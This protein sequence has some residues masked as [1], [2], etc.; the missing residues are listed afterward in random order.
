[1]WIGGD[2]NGHVGGTRTGFEREHVG[3]SWGDR[4]VEG[5]EILQFAQAYDLGIVNTFFQTK[6]EHTITYKSGWRMSVIDYILIRRNNTSQVKDCKVIPGE[7][8]ATQPRILT[9][10]ICIKT[11]RIVKL[12]MRKQHIKWWRLKDRDEIRKLASRLEVKINDV[13]EWNQ[14]EALLLDTAKSVL[15]Q[16]TG[17]GAYNE[18][19]AWWW[20]EEVQKAVK[21][22]RLKFKQYQQSRCDKDKEEF[23][24]ANKRAK[25]EVAK[26]KER[27]YKD[28]YDKLDSIEGQK[29]IYKLYKTRERRTRDITDIAY[30]KDSNG[31][32]LTDEDEIKARWEELFETLLNVENEREELE[33]T[34]PVQGPIPSVNDTEIKKQLSK[35]GRNKAYGPDDLPIEAIMMVEEL[36]P[37][38][39]TYI[40]QRIMA[41]GIPDSWK[42]SK[43]I[44]IFKNKGDI[45]ECNTYRGIKLMS[46]FMKLWERIIEA[47]LREIVIIRDNQF[48]FRPGMSTTEPV[49][50]LRQ[51]QEK[52]REKNKDLHMVCVDLEKAFDRMPRDLIWWCMRKKGVPEEYVK[53]V[54]DMYRSCKTKV[55]TQKGKLNISQ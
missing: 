11:K 54:Q 31:S 13:E 20:N 38:L 51:L 22:K 5:E 23:K 16:T 18:K 12:R 48:G 9:M 17:K 55:V 42:K 2:L 25:R 29:I 45:L 4:N 8:I 14:L 26:A 21:E 27:A 39:L 44:P 40:L 30:I 15:G 1:M 50:A 49:F 41:N 28:L 24:E 19:E 53:I 33:R 46:H 7:S 52:C 37:E 35:M 34:D 36:K 47:R 43:L 10:G 32:I 6:M 3:N